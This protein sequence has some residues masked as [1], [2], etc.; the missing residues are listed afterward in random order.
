MV[1]LHNQKCAKKE[2]KKI[3]TREINDTKISQIK[4]ELDKVNWAEKL[5]DQNADNAF[6]SFHTKLVET[7]E[8]LIPEK[9]K[10][11]SYK[12]M[13]R[14]PWLTVS[15]LKCLKRQHILYQLTLRSNKIEVIE[16]Y[17][18]Y[19]K[20]L[21][22]L[23]RYCKSQYYL[24]KRIEFKQNSKKLWAMINRVISK[25]NHKSESVDRIKVGSTYKTDAKSITTSFCNHFANVG[26]NYAEKIGKS[27]K[28]IENYLRNIEINKHS[29]FLTPVTENDLL[30]L[31]NALPNKLSSGFDNIN[32][33]LLKQLSSS[34]LKPMTICVNKSLLE[35]LFP[36]I[37]KLA[38]VY[39][40]FKS[41]DKSDTNNYRPISLLL[42]LSKLLEKVVYEKV[43][44]FLTDT[45]QI[46]SSQYGF[47]SRHSR[48]NA[49]GELLSAVLKGYQSNKYTVGLFLDL[50]KAFDTLQHSILLDK[51]HYYGIRGRALDWFW[52]YLSERK[53]RVKCCVTN[54]GQ[55]EYSEYQP[56]TF[57]TPQGS[58]LGPLIYLIFTN[59]LANNLS[60]CNSIMFADDTT[61]YKT[62]SSLRYLKTEYRTR[63][64]CSL[65]LVQ[66]QQAYSKPRKNIMH[67][68]QKKW[69][70]TGNSL[71]NKRHRN[72]LN[73]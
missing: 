11:I 13:T 36:N 65:R 69:K 2:A 38:D 18:N 52:S 44:Q 68:V 55:I 16:K 35:G 49:I 39:P 51:L 58:C 10:T 37:M 31:I 43:Y 72:C 12:R 41:K 62:H 32:N 73:K 40:L 24:N 42:T 15:L 21:R 47:R 6:C 20:T 46:Y 5:S 25:S 9:I 8:T 48:E 7:I 66:S 53:M 70:Q 61:L 23:I 27:N 28:R 30:R 14:D 64:V 63:Y 60:F 19:R 17:K 59:D 56:I 50:S 3:H 71:R 22:K 29:V 4:K 33:V 54:S 57:G 45:N 1:Y 34:L 67:S 26:K